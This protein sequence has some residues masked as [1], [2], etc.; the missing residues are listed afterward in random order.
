MQAGVLLK[1]GHSGEGN[2]SYKRIGPF[3]VKIRESKLLLLQLN[4]YS[5]NNRGKKCSDFENVF[6]KMMVTTIHLVRLCPVLNTVLS[7][8][9]HV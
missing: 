9:K 4:T 2:F 6:L 7:S 3:T 5:C 8:S 1:P